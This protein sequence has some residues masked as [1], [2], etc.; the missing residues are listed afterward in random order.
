MVLND[1]CWSDPDQIYSFVM[2]A[3]LS[4]LVNSVKTILLDFIYAQLIYI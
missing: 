3:F 2:K 4:F 1:N